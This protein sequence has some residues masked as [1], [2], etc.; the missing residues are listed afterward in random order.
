MLRR[1]DYLAVRNLARE[2]TAMME[3]LCCGCVDADRRIVADERRLRSAAEVSVAK[4]A[5]LVIGVTTQKD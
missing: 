5:S 1:D 4:I 3:T 2:L